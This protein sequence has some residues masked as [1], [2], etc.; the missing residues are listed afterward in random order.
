MI[1]ITLPGEPVAKI[2]P[3]VCRKFTYDP[4]DKL[5]TAA[6]FQ[7]LEMLQHKNFYKPYPKDF[8][9]EIQFDFYMT[10]K[11]G[12]E[13]LPEWGIT[14]NVSKKDI[15]N[16]C[17]FYLDV[18]NEIVYADDKQVTELKAAKLYD[19]N[20]RTEIRIMAR[21]SLV[22]EKTQEVLSYISKEHFIQLA[23][24]IDE[25]STNLLFVGE[26]EGTQHEVDCREAAY[27][28][29]VFAEKYASILTKVNKKF[30]G[31][32]KILKEE[33]EKAEGL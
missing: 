16:L 31:F 19:L 12:E 5:K 33:I 6:K 25:V 27:I 17:K 26:N 28:F 9:I 4:Q 20:P 22:S 24:D 21:R 30:P 7:L 11:V 15:D 23:N 13:K 2:R 8:P 29:C 32:A 10:P 1:M 14:E 3:R 18:M